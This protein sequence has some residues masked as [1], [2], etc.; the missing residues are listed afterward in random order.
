MLKARGKNM[1]RTSWE[2]TRGMYHRARKLVWM[3][4]VAALVAALCLSVVTTPAAQ[5]T[6]YQPPRLEGTEFPDL[7]GIW[8]AMNTAN[9]DLLAHAAG[10]SP[11]PR[12]LGAYGAMPAGLGVVEGNEIPYRPEVAAEKAGKLYASAGGRSLRA[13]RPGRSR[14][15]VLPAGCATRHVH[16]APL[17]DSPEHR[18]DPHLVRVCE[19]ESN[20]P[21]DQ[22]RGASGGLVD[23]VVERTM[24]REHAGCRGHGAERIHVVGPGGGLPQQRAARRRALYPDNSVSYSVRGHD[25]GPGRVYTTLDDQ[26]AALSAH[27][28]PDAASGVRMCAICRRVH[29]LDACQAAG[30]VAGDLRRSVDRRLGGPVA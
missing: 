1:L 28:S 20:Y 5:E 30:V 17:P 13:V 29:V 12:Q 15:E 11:V 26:Y 27:G 8:Q 2:G 6:D 21:H 7:N 14:G 19:R 10:P 23:G 22:S 9:W 4:A 18:Q 3:G 24:G 16:A 25:R